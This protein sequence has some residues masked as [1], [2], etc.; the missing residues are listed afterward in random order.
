MQDYSVSIVILASDESESLIK[1]V[2]Y[3]SE[4]CSRRPDKVVI[5]RSRRATEECVKTCDELKKTYGD[6]LAVIVQEKD[7]LGAAVRAGIDRVE[8]THM[9]IFSADISIELESLDRMISLSE[10][11]PQV[12]VKTSRWLQKGSFVG[13]GRIR[14]VMNRIAQMFLRVLFF[15]NLTDLTNP[16]QLIP[17][18]YER[19]INWKEDDFRILIE[20]TIVPVR[21]GYEIKE[22]PAKCFSR[23]EGSSKN[24]FKSPTVVELVV[25]SVYLTPY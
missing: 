4:H 11:N 14:F 6:Y 10:K 20:L 22:V 2:E 7:G 1:T 8:T 23:K 24:S 13:Y 19:K 5:V 21:L 3:I 9:T 16:V 17:M 25:V 15:S 12:I 18:E